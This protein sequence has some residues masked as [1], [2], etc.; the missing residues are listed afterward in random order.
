MDYGYRIDGT[1]KGKGYF[2][3]LRRPDGGVSTELSVG[4]NFD[5][6]ETQIPLLVPSL[7]PNEIRYLISGGEATPE[8]MKKAV[9]YARRRKVLGMS[10]FA[11][12]GEQ[13]AP[14]MMQL[15]MGY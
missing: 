2:G 3:E 4:V 10:P 6:K 12:N 8:I 14:P 1:P 13:Y 9:M 5:G 15:P 11:Q 7:S